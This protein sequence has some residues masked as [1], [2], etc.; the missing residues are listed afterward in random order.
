MIYTPDGWDIIEMVRGDTDE[1]IKKIVACW[2]GGYTTGDSWKINSGI[3]EVYETD[4]Y[5]DV[6][7]YSGSIYRCYK[8]RRGVNMYASGVVESYKAKLEEMNL[9]TIQ[10][11][12]FDEVKPK[13]ETEV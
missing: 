10:Y 6:H 11:A 5:Y 3:T 12:E 13:L 1:R 7:G 9:G 4:E 2:S 8:H